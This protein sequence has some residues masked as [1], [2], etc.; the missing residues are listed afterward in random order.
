[1]EEQMFDDVVTQPLKAA[2][3][4]WQDDSNNIQEYV[5]YEGISTT[6]GR[7]R[8]NHILLPNPIVSKNHAI[9]QWKKGAF[10][11]TDRGSSNGTFVNRRLIH[12]P[13]PLS[14]SDR[15]EIG[16]YRLSFYVMEDQQIEVPGAQPKG[17]GALDIDKLPS[18]VTTQRTVPRPVPSD[19]ARAKPAAVPPPWMP[20]QE[21][22]RP[23]TPPNPV[24]L[25]AEEM[26]EPGLGL[27]EEE[28]MAAEIFQES[29]PEDLVAEETLASEESPPAEESPAQAPFL[30]EE[31]FENLIRAV[32]AKQAAANEAALAEEEQ[33]SE[34]PEE[35]LEELEV[36]AQPEEETAPEGWQEEE[37][38]Q[39][40]PEE[41]AQEAQPTLAAEDLEHLEEETLIAEVEPEP[42]SEPQME[43]EPPS[44]PQV[45]AP[46]PPKKAAQPLP[47]TTLLKTRGAAQE[48]EAAYEELLDSLETAQA[49]AQIL[50]DKGL[51]FQQKISAAIGKLQ[52][53]VQEMKGLEITASEVKLDSLLASLPNTPY[54]VRLLMSLANNSEL[55]NKILKESLAL[56]EAI[57]KTKQELE[58]ALQDYAN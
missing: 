55:L 43:A 10:I 28:L 57:E 17:D 2:R 12:E 22:P 48:I 49:K 5:L 32:E 41:P 39:L 7:E 13:T 40:P 29:P 45:E 50:R 23:S 42:P 6:I 44:E 18:E 11:I 26:G 52:T 56:S 8:G 53:I 14:D 33:V 9:I 20:S 21:S 35:L 27:S 47:Q 30:S 46:P 36:Q 51:A 38:E 37:W 25:A 58:D 3:L 15:I 19:G 54:D 1:M 4:V 34:A 24:W 16:D 31:D